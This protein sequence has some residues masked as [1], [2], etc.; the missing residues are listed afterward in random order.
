MN[1]DDNAKDCSSLYGVY[2]K[3]NT[4][5]A[6]YSTLPLVNTVYE[7]S[8]SKTSHANMDMYR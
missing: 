3:C 5:T 4:N 1:C 7:T 2:T 8:T 6:D